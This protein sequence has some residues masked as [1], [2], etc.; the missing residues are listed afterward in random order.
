[1]SKFLDYFKDWKLT[2]LLGFLIVAIGLF[3]R[4]YNLTILP[5]FTDEAIYIRWSQIM[6][7]EPTLRF[8]PLSDGKQPL[9]MWILMFLVN[10]FSDPLFIGRFISVVSGM[11]TIIGLFSFALY[12]FKSKKVALITSLI[13]AV[14][15]FSLFFDR[16]ALVDSLLAMFGLWSLFLAVITVRTMR[17]DMAMF[18]GFALGGALLTK[19]PALFFVILL[20]T[21]VILS[22]WPKTKK[23]RL[24]HLGKLIFLFSSIYIISFAMYNIL[25]LGPNFHLIG[26]RNEDYVFPLSHLWLNPKDPFIFY[27]HRAWQWLWILG[28]SVVVVFLVLG[29]LLNI[30]RYGKEIVLLLAWSFFPLLV[31]AEF[32][33]VI[34]ARYILFSIPFLWLLAGSIFLVKQEFFQK[35]L[36]LG[37]V[38]FILHALSIDCLLLTNPEKA[39]LPR[40]ERSGYL[41]E[42]T[43]GTGI[44]EAAELIKT[45]HAQEPETQIIVGTEGYFGT[46]PDGLQMYLAKVPNVLVIGVGIDIGELP[47]SLKES[48]KAGNKTYLLANS[49]RLKFEQDFEELGLRVVAAYPKALRPDGFKEYVVHGPRDTLYLFEIVKGELLR[50]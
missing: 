43:A 45:I 2:I 17:L 30:R 11:V 4:I 23:E 12:L 16:M 47:T 6:V 24:T 33:K 34:T 5:V 42:W 20:P 19:S 10:R 25:R 26:S 3:L 21:T 28:P 40:G 38:I 27:F 1:M 29:S 35:L 44:R 31:Q 49:S 36:F 7:A 50:N 37:L 18:T 9:F 41:E 14:S 32:A 48:K 46:L 39:P 15:P 13:W 22:N 8:L